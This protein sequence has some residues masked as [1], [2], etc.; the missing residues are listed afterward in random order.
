MAC[1]VRVNGHDSLVPAC[2]TAAE[3]GMAVESQTD[4]IRHARRTA[5]ELLL[6]DHVGD[7][8]GPCQ[9]IC[10]AGMNIPLMIRQIA[11]GALDEAIVTVKRDIAIPAVLGRVCPAPCQS[12]CRRR[13]A[14]APLA[15][16]LLKRFVGDADLASQCPYTPNRP[17]VSGKKVAVVGCGAAGLSAAF[18]LPLLG[19]DCTV[20][21]DRPLG[22]GMLRYGVG[23]DRLP[24]EVLDAEMD[25]IRRLGAEFRQNVR[26]G[27]DVRLADLRRDYDAV[28]LA[29]GCVTA[30]DAEGLGVAGSPRGIAADNRTFRTSTDGVFAGG[31]AI[32]PRSKLAVRSAADG[33][34]AATAIDQYLRGLPVTGARKPFN[35]RIG[36]LLAGEIE[37]FMAEASKAAGVEPAAGPG[38]GFSKDEARNEALRCLHCD[39][40]KADQCRL[41]AHC[42]THQADA[43]RYK[44]ER[45]R[46]ERH[47]E[48]PQVVYEPGKCISCGLCVQIA[49]REDESL[50]LAFV[51]RGFDVRVAVPFNR[52]ISQALTTAAAKCVTACPTGALAFRTALDSLHQLKTN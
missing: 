46:F 25:A 6:S 4:E 48:H 41:R 45:R 32:R 31:G 8:M 16:C 51:G 50:G 49:S 30:G 14:D 42:Q 20:F 7:C 10:P 18:Y 15:I 11:S 28:L 27:R 12:G 29:V 9:V 36:N 26:I 47:A 34:E 23:E 38:A 19:H 40:R 44:A 21:D 37:Q 3:D 13:H 24:R 39:C 5:L 43:S 1:V 33:K 2:A 35:V 52:S 17:Q 22:G